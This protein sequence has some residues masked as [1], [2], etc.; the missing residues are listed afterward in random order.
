MAADGIAFHRKIVSG[1]GPYVLP[2]AI[3]IEVYGQKTLTLR[4]QTLF[5]CLGT[6]PVEWE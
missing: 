6:I 1:R 3:D 4:S 2:H 5:H